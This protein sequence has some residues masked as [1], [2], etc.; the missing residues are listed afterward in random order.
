LESWGMIDAILQHQ[1]EDI[2]FIPMLNEAYYWTYCLLA[3]NLRDS[4]CLVEQWLESQGLG[5]ALQY[6]NKKIFAYVVILWDEEKNQG[7][8]KIKHM[9]TGEEKEVKL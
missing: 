3:K 1:Q 7:I 8:Y 5:K 4:W 9:K 6:A 2:Y